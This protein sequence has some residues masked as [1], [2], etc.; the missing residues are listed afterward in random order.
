LR[1][2]N[3]FYSYAHNPAQWID[4][5]GLVSLE[6]ILGYAS[7]YTS[8]DYQIDVPGSVAATYAA[9]PNLRPNQNEPRT[10]GKPWGAG[11]GAAENDSQIPD[12]LAISVGERHGLGLVLNNKIYTFDISEACSIH[13]K[14]YGSGVGW[15]GKRDADKALDKNITKSCDESGAPHTVCKAI[16]DAYQHGLAVGGW[17]AYIRAKP[18]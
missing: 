10:D 11:C 3:N 6:T 2:G 16:G 4:P 5:L 13:D 7:A 14:G 1:G 9:D 8:F 18:E 12:K 17:K 15:N